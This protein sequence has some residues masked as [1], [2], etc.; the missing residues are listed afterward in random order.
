MAIIESIVTHLLYFLIWECTSMNIENKTPTSGIMYD[1]T[2]KIIVI[3]NNF[4]SLFSFINLTPPF[5][6]YIQQYI[7]PYDLLVKI[8]S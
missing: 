3:I 1:N 4:V 8:V 5:K 6:K 7:N 2:S